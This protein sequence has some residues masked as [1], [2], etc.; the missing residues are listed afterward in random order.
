MQATRAYV[1]LA[2]EQG[3]TPSQMALAFVNSRPFL[4]ANIIGA[5]SLQQLEEDIDSIDLTLSEETLGKIEQLHS[6]HPNPC[7]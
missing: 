2:H 4:A 6:Q 3:H 5:T 7:P 1:E